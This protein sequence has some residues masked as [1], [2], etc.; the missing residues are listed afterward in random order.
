MSLI[1]QNFIFPCTLFSKQYLV[2]L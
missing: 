1:S 2:V